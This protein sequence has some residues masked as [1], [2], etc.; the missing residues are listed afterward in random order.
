M[1]GK[2]QT[3]QSCSDELLAALSI[4]HRFSAYKALK[5]ISKINLQLYSINNVPLASDADLLLIG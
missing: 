5:N 4:K 2:Q 3:R 1:A